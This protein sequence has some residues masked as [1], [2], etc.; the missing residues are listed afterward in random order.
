M[1]FM[2]RGHWK[3]YGGL[4]KYFTTSIPYTL[5]NIQVVRGRG[6]KSWVI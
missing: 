6:E 3:S 1:L 4:L 5:R 2:K